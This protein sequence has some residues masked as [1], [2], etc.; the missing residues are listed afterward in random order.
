MN[1]RNDGAGQR[2]RSVLS[3]SSRAAKHD[4]PVLR[5]A[6]DDVRQSDGA[7]G[8]AL[9]SR[10]GQSPSRGFQGEEAQTLVRPPRRRRVRQSD[11]RRVSLRSRTRPRSF[12]L[13]E[14]RVRPLGS[15]NKEDFLRGGRIWPSPAGQLSTAGATALVRRWRRFRL[16]PPMRKCQRDPALSNSSIP[17][18]GSGLLNR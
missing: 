15:G 5:V 2:L 17:F 14:T 16:R 13:A 9:D 8:A 6:L 18:A 11:T 4:P 12:T 3:G 1:W 7:H 10:F